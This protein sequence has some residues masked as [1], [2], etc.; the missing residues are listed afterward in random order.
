MSV[1][2]V[3][4]AVNHGFD[5][6]NF[7]GGGCC[8]VTPVTLF[9]IR[10]KGSTEKNSRRSRPFLLEGCSDRRL[11]KKISAQGKIEWKKKKNSCTPINP[12]GLKKFIQGIRQRKKIPAARKFFSHPPPVPR[13]HSITFLMVRPGILVFV[14]NSKSYEDMINDRL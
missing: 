14:V 2:S 4:F 9:I 12:N 13:A 11:Y 7:L 5:F 10:S 6:N 8:C 1:F 3:F